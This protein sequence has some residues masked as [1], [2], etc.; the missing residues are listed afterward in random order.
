[1]ENNDQIFDDKTLSEMP[2]EIMKPKEYNNSPKSKKWLYIILGTAFLFVVVG[3]VWLVLR[4]NGG[5]PNPTSTN[6]VLMIKGP[7]EL[8]SG[9]E[10][11]YTV[12]YRNGENADMLGVSMEMF[13]PT[14]F[15]FKSGTPSASSS[16]GQYFNLSGVKQGDSGKVVIRGK[17]SG[18][19]NEDKT[20]KARL[21]YKL[22]N[23]NS[24]FVV[25]ETI[26]TAIKPPDLTLEV[27][28]P[29]DVINGQDTTFTITLT[30]VTS[31]DFDNLA[32]T[33]AYPTGFVFAASNPPVYKDNNYWKV[34][35]LASNA[36]TN[37]DITGSF[38]GQTNE[39]Q[40][41]QADL[42][43]IINNS[44]APQLAAS[45]T[46]KL[47]PSAL[48]VA[49]SSD[50]TDYVKLGDQ[51]NYKLS[52]QNN[53]T[54][55]LS[56]LIVTVAI[57]SSAVEMS[58]ISAT[59]AIVSG[60]SLIWRA[61]TL[62]NLS[63]LAPNEKGEIS[64]TVPVKDSLKNS[65][66]NQVVKLSANIS[67]DEMTKAT[68]AADSVLKLI[69]KL[70]M[71]VTG[72]Y[73]SGAAPMQVGQPTLFDITLMMTNL[74]NDLSDTQVVASLPLPSSA[75]KNIVV[76]DVEKTRLTFDPNSGKITW[77]IGDLP[78]FTGLFSPALR[79]TF[80]L[81]VVP[82]ET[83]RG[84]T[85]QLLKDIQVVGTDTFVGKQIQPDQIPPVDTG[86]INDDVLNLKGTSVQ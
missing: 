29:V 4:D 86:T 69:S 2:S 50:K 15:T 62:S 28:G 47:I 66:K 1:M 68:K 35:K 65:I 59:S 48:S 79:A 8:T 3:L 16:S 5:N 19:T 57:D 75:W 64:F 40:I 21:H 58:R 13:Y 34:G 76:P 67:S 36:S 9:N 74:S 39:E 46:F 12:T 45:A 7:S 38:T 11:E 10:A 20:I 60:N 82:T 71:S 30:N 63:L 52:Y 54:I 53:G 42:G 61:A 43:Q 41:V 49:L 32:V 44:F 77:K 84:K 80:R 14:G 6:V 23:F 25:E 81:E 55:G 78:A 51:I 70:G 17:L 37:I 85:I 18:S 24:E 27:N 56:N 33:T 22:S 31:Q 72:D 73:V 83:N 26:H